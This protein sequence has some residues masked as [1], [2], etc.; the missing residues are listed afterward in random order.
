MTKAKEKIKTEKY[1]INKI[2]IKDLEIDDDIYPRKNLSNDRIKSYQESLKAGVTFPPILVQKVVDA[3]AEKIIILDGVHR[4]EAYKNENREEI[5]A[6][7]WYD[8]TLDKSKPE[9][10][11]E[12]RIISTQKNLEHGLPLMES[13]IE[14]QCQR[15][16]QARS[17]DKLVGVEK[18]LAQKFKM[19]E[20][21]ISQ[22]VGA[23][24]NR[25]KASRDS[26]I[27]KLK[28]LGWSFSEIGDAIG[29]SKSGTQGAYEKFSVKEIVQSF[30]QGKPVEDIA[31]YYNL[32][33]T[34]TWGIVLGE[35]PD[36][37]RVEI[38][39][40]KVN[41][42]TCEL[43]PYDVWSHNSSVLIQLLYFYTKQENLVID[44]IDGSGPTIDACLL[45]G[46]HCKAYNIK[47]PE[48]CKDIQSVD[49]NEA[50][51]GLKK[52]ADMFFL[53]LP[54]FRKKEKERE[55]QSIANPSRKEYSN[56]LNELAN[57]CKKKL[58]DTGKV[59]AL[60]SDRIKDDPAESI[61]IH[62][63]IESFERAGFVV[64]RIIQCPLPTDQISADI[65][66]EHVGARE[67]CSIAR[68][69][70]IL[71]KGKIQDD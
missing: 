52:K 69:L 7:Y 5:E 60:I 6:I 53:K 3:E 22:M 38:L 67:L 68:Y 16:V 34:L 19:S 48:E 56:Y 23:L 32:D 25:K 59:A 63:F 21:R 36:K 4:V 1:K 37:E 39:S 49:T 71:Q 8:E 42:F 65:I 51:K 58:A 64:E 35:K 11:E 18:Y 33:R 41:D 50:I 70:V 46:R 61:F 14:L 24:I 40:K 15:I 13:D 47:S 12:L 66:N 29:L 44:P 30:Q 45:M 2:K 10:L 57:N 43:L 20:G 27:I 26:I 31:S 62:H 28:M 54:S 17:L 55:E 9:V